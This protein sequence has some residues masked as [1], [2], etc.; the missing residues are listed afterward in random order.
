M[1]KVEFTKCCK[2]CDV[3]LSCISWKPVK[4]NESCVIHKFSNCVLGGENKLKFANVN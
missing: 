2:I 3:I 1:L 4:E